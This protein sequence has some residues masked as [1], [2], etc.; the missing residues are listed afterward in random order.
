[1]HVST[2][3]EKAP[4]EPLVADSAL[5]EHGHRDTGDGHSL[6]YERWG[7]PDAPLIFH[8]H[9]GPGSGFND[10]HK[11]LYD[12]ER[13]HVLFMD[14]RGAGWSTP[15]ASTDHNTTRHLIADLEEFREQFGVEK[16]RLAGG[17]W[18][19]TLS[20][21]Y[22]IAH[23][24]RVERMVL[25]SVYLA[26]KF[27]TD[28]V[29]GGYARVFFPLEWM[30]FLEM[31]PSECHGSADAILRHYARQIRGGTPLQIQYAADQWVLWERIVSSCQH[32]PERL[33]AEVAGNRANIATA[34]LET[35]YFMHD[36]FIGENEILQ[37]IWRIQD[38]PC[39]VVHGRLDMCTP[40]QSAF[41]LCT[42]YNAVLD[43]TDG[44]LTLHW[45][46]SGHTRND[47]AMFS[48]LREVIA[49]KLA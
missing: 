6:Y 1:M 24:N 34:M 22:A 41:D 28:F 32:H 29:T 26:R 3:E 38:I 44:N 2:T 27:E 4:E 9:G 11:R 36:C 33:E 39:D 46:N 37:N 18:G 49:E 21:L 13:H 7:N 17:S 12:P 20:L 30:S 23:P 40:P 5:R 35:H 16:V 31:V 14:Q 8:L 25:W 19:S 48:K 47:P 43:G 15:F 42:A 45:V 10:D